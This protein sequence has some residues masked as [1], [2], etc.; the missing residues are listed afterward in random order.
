MRKKIFPLFALIVL[1]SLVLFS[2]C[3]RNGRF[4]VIGSFAVADSTPVKLYLLTEEKALIVDSVYSRGGKFKLEGTIG[5]AQLFLLKFFNGQTIYLAIFPGDKVRISIDNSLREIAYYVENSPD[6]RLIKELIDQQ[7]LV[8]KKIDALSH[9]WEV[10]RA[11]T[12]DRRLIDSRYQ[13]LLK[14]HKEYSRNFI[15]SHPK[16]LANILALYQNFGRKSQPLFDKY[17]DLKLFNF[18]DSNLVALYPQTN[19]VKALNSEVIQLQE[20]IARNKYVERVVV[21]G[22]PLPI[23]KYTDIKGDTLVADSTQKKPVLL[24]F[25][26]SWN[27]YSVEELKSLN[28]YHKSHATANI[29]IVTFSLDSSP[30]KLTAFLN[31]DSITLLVVCDFRYWDSEPAGRFAV[32]QI[33]STILT[34]REGMVIAKN[35]FSM[36]LVNQLN[37]VSK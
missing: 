33:P 14:N 27:P 31:T 10:N 26:A 34:N 25:W 18:V 32:K 8:L 5:S 37:E 12:S 35:I 2:G 28:A 36:E 7:N 3:N 17:D 11:D 19:A 4:K 9:E 13:L 16:S 29:Q 24:L 23:L 22:R 1:F 15:Y 6:S 21:E 30:E 20:Q